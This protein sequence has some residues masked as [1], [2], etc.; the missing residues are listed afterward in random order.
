MKADTKMF[1]KNSQ[2]QVQNV[3]NFGFNEQTNDEYSNDDNLTR[4]SCTWLNA[5]EFKDNQPEFVP[6]ESVARWFGEDRSYNVNDTSKN[7]IQL[8]L[9]IKL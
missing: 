7:Y 9:I 6:M 1:K 8:S 3:F 5:N 2:N 4:D